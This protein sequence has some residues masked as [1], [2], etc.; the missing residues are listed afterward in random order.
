MNFQLVLSG[1]SD[2]PTHTIARICY[3][4]TTRYF[5][6][7][8]C[9][10]EVLS[11]SDCMY[12]LDAS[13]FYIALVPFLHKKLNSFHILPSYVS[14]QIWS[15]SFSQQSQRNVRTFFKTASLQGQFFT[16][17]DIIA[18]AVAVKFGK[19]LL[20]SRSYLRQPVCKVLS[21]SDKHRQ[22]S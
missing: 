13:V 11:S 6:A 20:Q 21:H 2:M 9:Q 22:R 14:L 5:L 1:H 7:T 18:S 12:N 3:L 8:T 10:R 15:I 4:E 19:A 16:I 17:N